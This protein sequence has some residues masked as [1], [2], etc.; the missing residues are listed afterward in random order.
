MRF[1]SPRTRTAPATCAALLLVLL[2]LVGCSGPKRSVYRFEAGG[3]TR[4]QVE[5]S[6]RLRAE[7]LE[8]ID[9]GRPEDA[10]PLLSEA[11]SLTPGNGAVFNN[12][13]WVHHRA[14][15]LYPAAVAYRR[16][17]EL[18]PGDPVPLS[19]LGL[20]LGDA[21]RWDDA[22]AA[23]GRALALAPGDPRFESRHTYARVRRGDAAAELRDAL[24]RVALSVREGGW[25]VWAERQLAR[26]DGERTGDG[27]P[28]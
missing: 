28:R 9:D 19:N 7:A 1:S 24:E 17:A 23:H 6:A 22:A 20:V 5:E 27:E 26:L 12:L 16:A 13:G 11:S 4:A 21:G 10:L 15:R 8:R 2:P 3:P 18:R 25:G 14:G